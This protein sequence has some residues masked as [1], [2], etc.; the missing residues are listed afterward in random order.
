[1]FFP[2]YSV[3][4]K[5][6]YH[7]I[8]AISVELPLYIDKVSYLSRPSDILRSTVILRT[9]ELNNTEKRGNIKTSEFLALI[10]SNTKFSCSKNILISPGNE[11]TFR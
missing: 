6:A 2:T 3:L 5:S 8:V 11:K 1:M 7:L 4:E 10:S 9:P